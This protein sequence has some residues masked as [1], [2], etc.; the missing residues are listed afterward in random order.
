MEGN[1]PNTLQGDRPTE[2]SRESE[3]QTGRQTDRQA[4]MQ[5]DERIGT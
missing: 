3:R 1:K 4:D 5:A 2:I